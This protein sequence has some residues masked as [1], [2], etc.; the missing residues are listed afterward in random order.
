MCVCVCVYRCKCLWLNI[1]MHTHTHTHTHI[2]IYRYERE[3]KH[4]NPKEINLY[5][6]K[7]KVKRFGFNNLHQDFDIMSGVHTAKDACWVNGRKLN[8][9][10]K[11]EIT[12]EKRKKIVFSVLNLKVLSMCLACG[13]MFENVGFLKDQKILRFFFF[14]RE[15]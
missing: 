15:I 7:A 3:E 1:F 9:Y 5:S 12:K 8:V 4:D 2:Y 13:I 10:N 14:F 6:C 11:K